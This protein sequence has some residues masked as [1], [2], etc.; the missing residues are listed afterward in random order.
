VSLGLFFQPLCFVPKCQSNFSGFMAFLHRTS[1]YYIHKGHGFS[2]LVLHTGPQFKH[3]SLNYLLHPNFALVSSFV[4]S[5]ELLGL[6][7]LLLLIEILSN[8]LYLQLTEVKH[9]T[10]ELIAAQ[11]FRCRTTC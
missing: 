6:F 11:Y 2:V 5:L 1:I 9:M 3:K 8:I 7:E 4:C 10:T